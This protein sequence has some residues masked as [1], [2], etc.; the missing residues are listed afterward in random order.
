MTPEGRNDYLLARYSEFNWKPELAAT[1]LSAYKHNSAMEYAFAKAGGLLIAGPDPT[2][3]GS[4]I[5]GFADHRKLSYWWTRDS[6]PSRRS[7]SPR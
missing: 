2:G 6:L 7:G 4:V 3:D 5:P 1:Y